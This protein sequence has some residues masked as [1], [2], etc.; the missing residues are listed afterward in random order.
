M[1]IMNKVIIDE[2]GMCLEPE[3]IVAIEASQKAEQVIL[4]GDHKQLQPIITAKPALNLDLSVSLFERWFDQ[5][6]A[7][8]MLKFQYRMVSLLNSK[9]P[10]VSSRTHRIHG[11]FFYT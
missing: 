10:I 1:N 8:T 6:S 5:C 7:T 4:I 2:C 11:E 3:S 9:V